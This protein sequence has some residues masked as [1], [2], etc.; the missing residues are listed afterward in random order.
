MVF[1]PEERATEMDNLSLDQPGRSTLRI[2]WCLDNI[3]DD[4][5]AYVL[6]RLDTTLNPRKRRKRGRH[7]RAVTARRLPL[8]RDSASWICS[9]SN[10]PG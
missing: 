4:T 6:E 9:A 8:I 5:S 1:R 10:S 7:G 3:P 2:E